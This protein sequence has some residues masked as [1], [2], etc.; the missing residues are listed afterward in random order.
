MICIIELFKI[1]N[2]N[3]NRC[4]CIIFRVPCS[5]KNPQISRKILKPTPSA[6]SS[7]HMPCEGNWVD[8]TSHPLKHNIEPVSISADLHRLPNRLL[9]RMCDTNSD[10]ERS[11][12]ILKYL[13]I[14]QEILRA[15]K[16]PKKRTKHPEKSR[17]KD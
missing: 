15:T 13:K 7:I 10:S 2:Y 16:N 12:K 8:G 14:P 6:M 3:N 1:N 5:T 17:K 9:F 4:L 11:R